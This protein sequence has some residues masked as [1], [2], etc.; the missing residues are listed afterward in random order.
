VLITKQDT[1]YMHF[2]AAVI[3][4]ICRVDKSLDGNDASFRS[5]HCVLNL[6]FS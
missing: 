2:Q 5:V 6:K 3:T 4:T 1:P